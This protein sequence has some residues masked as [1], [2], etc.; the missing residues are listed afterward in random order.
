MNGIRGMGK[1]G[2]QTQKGGTSKQVPPFNFWLAYAGEFYPN[3]SFVVR[4][5]Y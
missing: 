1:I 4:S 5:T 3:L 2:R